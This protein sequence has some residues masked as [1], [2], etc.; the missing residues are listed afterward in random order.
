MVVRF[1]T[2]GPTRTIPVSAA[3][4]AP[5]DK[6]NTVELRHYERKA[7]LRYISD[8]LTDAILA[9]SSN[10]I[11][12]YFIELTDSG[13]LGGADTK[14][15]ETTI[16][17]AYG[18]FHWPH[19]GEI[20]RV[21]YRE[22]GEARSSPGEA[23]LNYFQRLR[24]SHPNFAILRE[25][26]HKA[27]TYR[28]ATESGTI[29]LFFS[30]SRG[31]WD[32]L[33]NAYTQP[34]ENVFIPLQMRTEIVDTISHFQNSRDRFQRFGRTYKLNMLFTGVPGS[35]KTS[36]AKAIAHHLNLPI[37][38][39]NFTKELTDESFIGLI[40]D[41]REKA[42]VL[43]EDV[44]AY[45]EERKAKDINISFSCLINI[46]DGM[47]NSGNGSITILTANNPDRLD[48]ALIRPGRIDRIFKF[49]YPRREE[50]LEACRMMTSPEMAA[51]HFDEFYKKIKG[52][53]MNMSAI[54]D[55]F[56]RY[57]EEFWTAPVVDEL[58]AQTQI[59]REIQND[60]SDKMYL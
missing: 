19:N 52:T 30:K 31:F 7:F 49:D 10:D 24:V 25:F 23:S 44:D 6:M 46:L 60:K 8:H 40:R 18:E 36:L 5:S 35:G 3:V 42:I 56:F 15:E 38:I 51:A 45:F 32:R 57:P 20:F 4:S 33:K 29:K 28:T 12:N 26:I 59:I 58:L 34:L 27:L 53:R 37:Y 43:M 9:S 13:I 2:V 17:P 39:F 41:I 1:R 21:E 50:I 11:S 47:L 22:E 48:P 55:V 14:K 54:V 16:Y